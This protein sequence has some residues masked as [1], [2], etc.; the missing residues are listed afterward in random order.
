[1]RYIC[2]MDNDSLK[3]LDRFEEVLEKGL[4]KICNVY[5]LAKDMMTGPDVEEKWNSM[6]KDYTA[7]AVGNF[8]DYPNA[9]LGFAAYLGMAV[10]RDW[11]TDWASSKNKAYRDYYGPHGFDDMDDHIVR[12]ILD[13]D[14]KTTHDIKECLLS[15]A[16]STLGL[17]EHEQIETQTEFG[18]YIL[19]RCWSVMYKIGASIELTRRGYARHVLGV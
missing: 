4:I 7:D 14:E 19:V 16:Q 17:I 8:N 5:G 1:M 2:V 13:L 11:D 9:A 18:F 15:C 3:Q 6:C 12:D 10:V